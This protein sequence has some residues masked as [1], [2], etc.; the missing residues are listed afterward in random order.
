MCAAC[1][2]EK[3]AFRKVL[4]DLALKGYTKV[5]VDGELQ[6][7]EPMPKLNAS[8]KHDLFLVVDL[9]KAD[10]KKKARLSDAI[11][12]CLKEGDGEGFYCEVKS[13][14]EF[15]L[16]NQITF[17]K[18]GGCPECGY[19]WPKLDS[20]YFSPNSLGRC[21]TCN[22][23]GYFELSED[24]EDS[25]WTQ[26]AC[27]DC[28]GTGLVSLLT[29]LKLNGKNTHEI[30]LMSIKEFKEFI[31]SYL[32]TAQ[33]KAAIRVSEELKEQVDRILGVGLSYIHLSRR[34]RSLSPGEGQRLKLA[35][36]LGENLRGVL[37]VLDEPS[38]GLHEKEIAGIWGIIERL[39][40]LGN[41]VIIVDHDEWI[42]N[43]ADL[44]LDLGPDGGR[45]GGELLAKFTPKEAKKY[46]DKSLTAKY[47]TDYQESNFKKKKEKGTG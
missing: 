21:Q 1:E 5:I 26:E 6:S 38:Q 28:E 2:A 29:G 41:T 25:D 11:E 24:D 23:L 4:E 3:G 8:E 27:S 45:N 44:I 14:L 35:N 42:I 16:D 13:G 15:D 12:L 32:K 33:N 18:D 37:Y 10:L 47:L 43:K 34:I 39:K 30:Y 7:L 19:A 36:V 31:D 20:R 9:V 17:T 46:A 40:K 22:G